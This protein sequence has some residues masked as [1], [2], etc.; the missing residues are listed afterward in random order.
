MELWWK[1]LLQLWDNAPTFCT[2]FSGVVV[3][4]L[5]IAAGFFVFGVCFWYSQNKTKKKIKQIIR[6]LTTVESPQDFFEKFEDVNSKFKDHFLIGNDWRNLAESLIFPKSDSANPRVIQTSAPAH[7][8]FEPQTYLARSL[9][10]PLFNAVPNYLTGG[11]IFFT[12][13]GL[14][15]GIYQAQSGFATGDL[16]EITQS[17]KDLLGG[18]S[19]A[20]WTSIVGL[21]CSISFSMLV[22]RQLHRL[23]L[24]FHEW[25]D[26]LDRLIP[27]VTPEKLA[28]EQLQEL[29][30]QSGQL[31][32]FNTDLAASIA[33]A[34]DSRI[35]NQ[36][37]TLAESIQQALTS[38]VDENIGPRLDGIH[39][40]ME[41]IKADRGEALGEMLKDITE[42]FQEGLQGATGEEFKALAEAVNSLAET[43][44]SSQQAMVKTQEQVNEAV[45][46]MVDQ[47]KAVLEQ[48]SATIN[49][50]SKKTASD[51]EN[52]GKQLSGQLTRAGNEVEQSFQGVV[53]TIEKT[54]DRFQGTADQMRNAVNLSLTGLKELA[55]ELSTN[56]ENFK[57]AAQESGQV[58]ASTRQV[59]TEAKDAA[60]RMTAMTESIKNAVAPI[61]QI[62]QRFEAAGREAG[63][64]ARQSQQTHEEMKLFFNALQ[65]EHQALT[66]TWERYQQ[67][68]ADLDETLKKVFEEINDGLNAYVDHLR[69]YVIDLEK[70]LVD[71]VNALSGAVKEMRDL[72]D[73]LT[74]LVAKLKK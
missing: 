58:L 18:A 20:F 74:D 5:V 73:E 3:F 52:T 26:H 44:S 25:N 27:L 14:A 63:E 65:K 8:F 15:A 19:L 10:L 36:L 53:K 17:L 42:K 1:N 31:Q 13:V 34:L 60:S 55:A 62:A 12:F 28:Y 11:G 29:K 72:P 24:V 71:G 70:H 50:S 56:T 51:L 2:S 41:G 23:P 30:V 67:R 21:F 49:E 6:I 22:K 37:N 46:V 9:N 38:L 33:E 43:I 48:I 61:S 54:V 69:G 66:M 40:T 32:R 59:L 16:T 68:F 39:Q 57:A 35:S 4:C 45:K 7:C 47:T 64:A